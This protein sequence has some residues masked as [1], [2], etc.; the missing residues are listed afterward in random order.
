M[1]SSNCPLVILQIED[2]PSDALLTAFALKD[3]NNTVHSVPDGKQALVFLRQSAAF[4]D[5]P[6]PDLILLDLEL[7]GMNGFDVLNF[8]K[9]DAA[10]KSIPVVVF[11]TLDTGESHL[12]ATQNG[13]NSYVVKPGDFAKFTAVVQSIALY[14]SD[15]LGFLPRHAVC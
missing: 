7:P 3:L 11:S 15:I 1:P 9:S 6:R 14:W 2:S 5:A 10:L 12:R 8:I 4:A 13:A